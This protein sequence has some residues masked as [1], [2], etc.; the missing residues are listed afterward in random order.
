MCNGDA[1][2]DET[3]IFN[4]TNRPVIAD[5]VSPL[6]SPIRAQSFPMDSR[7]TASIYVFDEPFKDHATD[8]GIEFGYLLICFF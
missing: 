1:Q 4:Y 6:T 8:T 5:T 3:V 2:N 7:V